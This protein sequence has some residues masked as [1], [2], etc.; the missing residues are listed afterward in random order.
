MSHS[1]SA[2]ST[3]PA[4]TTRTETE[5]QAIGID[6]GGTSIKAARVDTRDGRIV[7]PV[8][9]VPTPRTPTPEHVVDAVVR[10][11]G[12]QPTVMAGVGFPGVVRRG[13][14]ATA[15]NLH[16][17]WI[18]QDIEGLFGKGLNSPAVTVVNDADAAGLAEIHFGSGV[19]QPGVAMMVTLGTGIGTAIFNQGTLVPNTEFGHLE[20]DG[21]EAEQL[22]SGRARGDLTW[23]AWSD[24]LE[25]VLRAFERLI[26]PD[27]FI[28]GGGISAEFRRFCQALD[29]ITPVVA[30]TMGNEAGI[31]GAALAGG[32]RDRG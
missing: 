19:G 17:H 15:A 12:D 4:A 11:V 26:W 18:G 23:Q 2:K 10:M 22:A 29:T 31:I 27:L 30:A 7:S 13:V 20:V 8:Q 3:P 5:R 14:A 21:R 24:H 1:P 6:I 25:T 28:I 32:S 9:R 16:P